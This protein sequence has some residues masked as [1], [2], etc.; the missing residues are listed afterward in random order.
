MV[1]NLKQQCNKQQRLGIL[2]LFAQ[3]QTASRQP[4]LSEEEFLGL[5]DSGL[6]SLSSE[7]SEHL[8]QCSAC[9][10]AWLEISQIN[11]K[12]ES[13]S[14]LFRKTV[15]GATGSALAIAA[16]VLLF[17]YSPFKDQFSPSHQT[18]DLELQEEKATGGYTL[19]KRTQQEWEETLPE[20]VSLVAPSSSTKAQKTMES[21]V[22]EKAVSE[23]NRQETAD[24][25]DEKGHSTVTTES[26]ESFLT[27]YCPPPWTEKKR[28]H[29]EKIGK[30]LLETNLPL[31]Q[32][33]LLSRVL[34]SLVNDDIKTGKGICESLTTG[35]KKLK[36]EAF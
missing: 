35:D 6:A 25:V 2:A 34:D 18:F 29:L 21:P 12:K 1:D 23:E 17:I 19:Q 10:D 13:R 36:T 14:P 22:P 31:E 20:P 9:Y 30:Q 5:L 11:A 33:E 32:K 27:L 8:L 24:A 15:L 4:C 3:K 7:K 16:S 26:F 28:T